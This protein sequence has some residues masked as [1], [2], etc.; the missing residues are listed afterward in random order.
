M[1]TLFLRRTEHRGDSSHSTVI[2]ESAKKTQVMEL[3]KATVLYRRVAKRTG[4]MPPWNRGGLG[5]G[6]DIQLDHRGIFFPYIPK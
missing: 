4:P 6:L 3:G 5:I 1:R 2:A